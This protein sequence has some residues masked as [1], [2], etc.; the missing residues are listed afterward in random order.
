MTSLPLFD[1]VSFRKPR[2]VRCLSVIAFSAMLT[3]CA[4]VDYSPVSACSA[5]GAPVVFLKEAPQGDNYKICGSITLQVYYLADKSVSEDRIELLK[6]EAARY[7]AN[8]VFL[9]SDIRTN[10]DPMDGFR[11]RGKALAIQR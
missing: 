9:V 7:G 2:I 11:S 6:D 1:R 10:Y 8:A 3:G 5:Y 4:S